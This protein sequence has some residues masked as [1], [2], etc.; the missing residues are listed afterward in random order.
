[1]ASLAASW[2]AYTF[3][4]TGNGYIGVD[5]NGNQ[6]TFDNS[7]HQTGFYSQKSS[8]HEEARSTASVWRIEKTL[9][10]DST[11]AVTQT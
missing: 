10:D 3:T 6:V 5:S 11:N 7:L 9:N 4:A 1:M 2:S 8:W